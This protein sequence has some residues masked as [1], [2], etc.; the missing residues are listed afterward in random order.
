[1]ECFEF[2][3]LQGLKNTI[4]KR[5]P[6]IMIEGANRDVDVASFFSQ[7]D[8]VYA[9]RIEKKLILFDKVSNSV[10]GFFLA[11]ERVSEYRKRGTL[12]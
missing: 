11:H 8:Y 9:E 1:V 3:A 6:L 2:Q 12:I 4:S 5:R 10:N 7:I